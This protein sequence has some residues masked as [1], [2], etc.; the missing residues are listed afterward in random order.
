VSLP[1]YKRFP[2][3]FLEGTI[4]LSFEVKGAYAIVLDLIY[5]RD[6]RLPD[7]ARYIAGQ[8][9]CS[10]RK[11]TAIL[12][13][14]VEAGKLQV[15]GGIISNFRAD[16]LTEESRKYQDKQA[17]IAG[18]PRKNKPLRQPQ[19]SQSESEPYNNARALLERAD[20]RFDEALNAYPA[21]G[22]A[23]TSVPNARRLWTQAAIDAGGEDVL[24]A[25]VRSF[26]V[27][28]DLAKRDH[29]APGFHRWLLEERWRAERKAT[30]TTGVN[31][32]GPPDIRAAVVGERG[33]AFASSYL[34]PAGWSDD[35][36]VIAA[37]G[38]A[39]EKLR[40]LSSLNDRTI[41]VEQRQTA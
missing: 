24:L 25:A 1:Y 9:G 21:R 11:W 26:A 23:V 22:V 20:D 3:D 39:A 8:L 15:V 14:L 29:G 27:S 30:A 10:V 35:G 28:P 5:M 41:S 36:R 6:G 38:Y 2:R 18:N 40:G 16:Y 32:R 13:E 4:G 31:W 19:A 17:E 7:D 33:E 34:D 37:T 12:A